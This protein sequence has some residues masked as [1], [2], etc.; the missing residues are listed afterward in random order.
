MHLAPFQRLLDLHGD[1]VHRFLMA[2][3]GPSDADDCFQETAI[4]ALRAY[5]GLTSAANLRGWL[6]TIAHRKAMDAHRSRRRRPVPVDELPEAATEPVPLDG[7]LWAQVERLPAKQRA[8]VVH[9][10]WEDLPYRDVGRV[11]GCSEAA[12][13]RNV[14]EG[15]RKLREM[16]DA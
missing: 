1:A 11:M 14:F 3:A 5:P 8:A 15:L 10:F 7:G 16:N 13:R 4:A 9:R 2:V 12:A 6:F